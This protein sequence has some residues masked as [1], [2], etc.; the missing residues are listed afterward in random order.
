VTLTEAWEKVREILA[1]AKL[2]HGP[3][4]AKMQVR[5]ALAV[6]EVIQSREAPRGLFDGYLSFAKTAM[7]PGSYKNAEWHLLKQ[8]KPLHRHATE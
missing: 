5:A 8:A 4:A 6:L 1:M 7:R 2:G 3:Q